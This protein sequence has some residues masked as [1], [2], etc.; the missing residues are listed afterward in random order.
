MHM[1]KTSF[2]AKKEAAAA[3]SRFWMN[4]QATIKVKQGERAGRGGGAGQGRQ[5]RDGRETAKKAEGGG[6]TLVYLVYMKRAEGRGHVK[7]D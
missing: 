1:G 2:K 7:R 5:G 4:G 3:I 6:D